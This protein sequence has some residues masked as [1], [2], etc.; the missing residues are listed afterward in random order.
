M[1]EKAKVENYPIIVTCK[2]VYDFQSI[3]FQ[4]T[5]CDEEDRKELFET[6]KGFVNSLKEI[7][8]ESPNPP[9]NG[10]KEAKKESKKEEMASVGQ[11]NYLIG[12]GFP[13][14]DAKKLTKKQASMCIKE[15]KE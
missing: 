15:W 7:S 4:W 2:A 9:R 10:K 11:I 13:E 14:E 5:I 12:L 6:Y 8:E 3:E 1:S